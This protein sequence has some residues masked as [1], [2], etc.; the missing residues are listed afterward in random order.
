MGDN[1]VLLVVEDSED[2]AWLLQWAFENLDAANRIEVV[3]DGGQAISYLAG[4]DTYA[5]RNRYPLPDLVLLDLKM[6]C[7]DGFEVLEWIR[8]EPKLAGLPVLALSIS[9]R[10]EDVQRAYACGAN[11][12]LVKPLALEDFRL[13]VATISDFWLGRAWLPALAA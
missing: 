12:Y 9:A 6:P 1:R 3:R 4:E 5:D 10:P 13:L 8:G 7:H 2:D 11:S